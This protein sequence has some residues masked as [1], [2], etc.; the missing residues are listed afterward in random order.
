MGIFKLLLKRF[1]SLFILLFAL[2][3]IT[4][5]S[6]IE[7]L[8]L[9]DKSGN[10]LFYVIFSYNGNGQL[11]SRTIYDYTGKPRDTNGYVL[12]RTNV[13]LDGS[14]KRTNEDYLDAVDLRSNWST[15]SY[16]ANGGSFAYYD[17]YSAKVGRKE[18]EGS[19]QASS[20]TGVFEFF[21]SGNSL[22]HKVE[23]QYSGSD[24]SRI[25]IYDKSNTLTHYAT[26]NGEVGNRPILPSNQLIKNLSIA[27]LPDRIIVSF[28]LQTRNQPSIALYDLQGRLTKVLLKKKLNKGSHR[29]VYPMDTQKSG[30]YLVKIGIGNMKYIHRIQVV[31]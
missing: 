30:I 7:R 20:Q 10:P 1:N 18:Y 6:T 12:K 16:T 22:T 14:G 28:S 21:N 8:D 27:E 25:N 9:F 4:K 2:S 13:T 26:V 17:H 29:F 31:K 19:Y 23:Y 24:I 3:Q 5:A 11:T 15:Y